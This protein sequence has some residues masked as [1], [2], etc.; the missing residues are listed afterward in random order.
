MRL[1]DRLVLQLFMRVFLLCLISF[2]VIFVLADLFEKMDNFIDHQASWITVGRFY[3]YKLPEIVRLTLP[4]DVLLL[5]VLSLK[6]T[7]FSV[8]FD[9][10]T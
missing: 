2:A 9:S 6:T 1:H 8:G 10:L 4:V 7:S 5:Q 3:A